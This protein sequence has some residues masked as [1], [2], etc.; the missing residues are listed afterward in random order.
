[1][2]IRYFELGL[3]YKEDK[4]FRTGDYYDQ[5]SMAIKAD[6]SPSFAEAE[7]FIKEDM[8]KMGYTGINSITEIE[9]WEVHEFFDDTDIDSWKVLSGRC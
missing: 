4:D 6:H 7:E 2:E 3:G 9:E 1:M 5:Y 8:Q